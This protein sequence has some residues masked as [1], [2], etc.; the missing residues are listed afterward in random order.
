M[1]DNSDVNLDVYGGMSLFMVV[2][3]K[4]CYCFDCYW[5]VLV[6]IDNLMDCCYYMFYLYL[7]CIFYGELKWLL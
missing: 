4:V 7:G 6:G 1:L 5:I 2:D 3:L